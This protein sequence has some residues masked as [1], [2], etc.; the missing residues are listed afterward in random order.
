MTIDPGEIPPPSLAQRLLQSLRMRR[1]NKSRTRD[2]AADTPELLLES[3]LASAWV[4]W[5]VAALIAAGPLLTIAGAAWLRA[6]VEAET[7]RLE[8]ANAPRQAAAVRAAEARGMLRG[9]LAAP[10]IGPTLDALAAALP[11][12]DRL[13]AATVDGSGVLRIEIATVDPDRLRAALRTTRLRTL[14]ET[15]QQR[16][17]GV[18]L[19]RW[20]GRPA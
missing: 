17:E 10:A 9:A 1:N 2:F 7:A 13:T 20:Q 15:A 3:P 4:G 8:A 12:E 18:L 16:G 14:R 6:G 11:A 5:A 19:V